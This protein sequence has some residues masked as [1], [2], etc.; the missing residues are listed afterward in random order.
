MICS[1]IPMPHILTAYTKM[2][3]T[4]LKEQFIHVSLIYK[5]VEELFHH[6]RIFRIFGG[7]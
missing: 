4:C 6:F 3:Y 5:E 2:K 7:V 1:H